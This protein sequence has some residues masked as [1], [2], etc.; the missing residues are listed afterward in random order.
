MMPS[1]AHKLTCLTL[2]I[3]LLC[4]LHHC[5]EEEGE[6]ARSVLLEDDRAIPLHGLWRAYA[7]FYQ[8]IA[9]KRVQ[10]AQEAIDID[11]YGAN[12]QVCIHLFSLRHEP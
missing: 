3:L 4:K 2:C 9:G 6:A 1:L 5:F 12:S 8:L 10:Q 7:K 11:A